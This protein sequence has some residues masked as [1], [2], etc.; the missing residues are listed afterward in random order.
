MLARQKTVGS[1]LCIGLDPD[2]SRIPEVCKQSSQ[3]I[4]E[5]NKAIIDATLELASCYKPQIAHYASEAAEDELLATI[6]YLKQQNVPVLLDAKRGDVGSTA[7]MYARE[8]FERYGADAVTV[9]PYLGKDSMAPYLDYADRGVFILCRTSNPGGS[10][11]QNLVL[12]G[13]DTL[14]EHVAKQAR[15]HWNA[16]NNVGL[17][18]GA[19]R[20]E[21]LRQIRDICGNMTLLLP[22]VGAQGADV[23]EMVGA[24]Q[25]GGMLVSSSRAILY[26]SEGEDFAEKAREVALK[27]RDEVNRYSN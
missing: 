13:G 3:P 15:D 21:E 6:E 19:T 22:G 27:T 8:L 17:V 5:F 26:A 2:L 4:F 10:D 16:N 20:P 18:V 11:L 24:G 9:N 1:R 7:E 25:G 14:F 12:E 23:K